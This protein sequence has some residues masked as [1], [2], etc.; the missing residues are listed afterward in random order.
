MLSINMIKFSNYSESAYSFVDYQLIRLSL[1][2]ADG[3]AGG[4]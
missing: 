3:R 4:D 1:I 2:G